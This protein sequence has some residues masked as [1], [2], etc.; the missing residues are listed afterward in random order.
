MY[1]W[2]LNHQE[3]VLYLKF[4]AIVSGWKRLAFLMT[5]NLKIFKSK[6]FFTILLWNIISWMDISVKMQV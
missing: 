6:V 5:N 2:G 1:L 3:R 4:F